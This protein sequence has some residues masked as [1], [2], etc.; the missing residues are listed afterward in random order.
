[1]PERLMTDKY[2][3]D[4]IDAP[5]H[6]RYHNI[7]HEKNQGWLF[8][9]DLYIG[10][11]PVGATYDENMQD[12]IAT[13]K[14]I[15]TLDFDLI[16]CAHSGRVQDGK[17]MFKKKMDFL[18]GVQDKVNRLR[19]QGMDDYEIDKRLYPRKSPVTIVSRGEWSSYN[20]VNTI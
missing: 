5:G 8:T 11:K 20:I 13:I 15:L 19:Q 9:G 16:F 4:V 17:A 12:I 3:L 14:E 1:M 7:F 6:T 2:I 18:L 10:T